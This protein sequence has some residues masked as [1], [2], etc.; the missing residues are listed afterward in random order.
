MSPPDPH[1]LAVCT[2]IHPGVFPY[3]ADWYASLCSQTDR[4]FR[5]WIALDG[6][7]PAD[8]ARILGETPTAQWVIVPQGQTPAA[9]RQ[10]LLMQ[11][12]AG[13]GGVVLVDSDDI[14]HPHRVEAA[15]AAL[16]GGAQ[17][18]ACALRLID[19]S[20]GDLGERMGLPAGSP[21]EAVLP[22]YNVFG[23]SNTVWQSRLLEA[24]LPIP[25]EVEI[26]DWYLATRAWLLGARLHFDARVGMDYRQHAS[27]MVRVRGPFPPEQV[28]A[29]T[30]RVSRHLRLVV[31]TPPP[32]AAPGRLAKVESLSEE[33]DYFAA[34]V[35]ADAALLKEYAAALAALDLPPLWWSSVAHPALKHM[36][37]DSVRL[38]K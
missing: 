27:N 25:P 19:Q 9:I 20:G 3:L 29:D 32:A 5:L 1:S 18:S 12:V 38:S 28:L 15:R 22:R 30:L 34:R 26:V 6:L 31:A 8:V 33:V 17:L 35:T 10:R 16:V 37:S 21:V 24:C 7:Q 36:W 13:S 4:N 2:T 11:V 23:L 14:M